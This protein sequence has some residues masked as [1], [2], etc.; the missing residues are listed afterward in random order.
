VGHDSQLFPPPERDKL[1]PQEKADLLCLARAL[2]LARK[3]VAL[4]SPN[5]CVGAV[6]VTPEGGTVG[7][8]SHT[9]DGRKHAEV[10]AIEQ[11]GEQTRGATLYL[12]LEP[13]SHQGRTAPCADAVITA[14]IRRVVCSMQDPNPQIAGQGFAKL[15]AAGIEV[16]V[17]LLQ[18][19][20]KTLNEAFAKYIRHKT[21]FVLL[22]SAMTLDGKIA[23]PPNAA[24][25]ADSK[26]GT[27][28]NWITGEAA[29]AHV[30]QLRHES[31]AILTGIG[32]ILADDPLLT[33]RTAQPRRH[34]LLRV[35]L[36]SHLRLP[37]N[38][39]I[40]QTAK[41]DVLVFCSSSDAQHRQQ[42]GQLGVRIE[43][44]PESSGG[45]L[46]LKA[47]VRRLGEL[48]ITSLIIEGGSHLNTAALDDGIVDKVMLY[49]APKVFG[50]A[51]VPFTAVL[52]KPLTLSQATT[53]HFGE[54]FALEGYLK[55][56]YNE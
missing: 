37:L 52:K 33:D 35:V 31:D 30:Q 9:Y 36:D 53:H 41:D 11:A 56:P 46:N 13:C 4:T 38:S 14:G 12:N 8:G 34:P 25:S 18:A 10:L 16:E 2:E 49:V 23:P 51:A 44:V 3:G 43:Q 17:G 1:T 15:R 21:P 54:D 22:K 5:P 29:R 47:I 20:A 6:I 40:A 19:E 48:E 50:Q 28:T 42:L 24:P 55:G 39:R 27:R 45:P 26:G 32:T 7:E